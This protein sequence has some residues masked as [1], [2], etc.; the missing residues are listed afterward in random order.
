MGWED[1]YRLALP[2][3]REQLAKAGFRVAATL[4]EVFKQA[5]QKAPLFEFQHFEPSLL[6]RSAV[7]LVVRFRVK[8]QGWLVGLQQH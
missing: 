1:Y 5:A 2:I 3:V 6:S 8:E 7:P 4:N